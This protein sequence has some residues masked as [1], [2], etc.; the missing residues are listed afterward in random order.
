M[1][2]ATVTLCDPVKTCM[3]MVISA[4]NFLKDARTFV[5][6]IIKNRRIFIRVLSFNRILSTFDIPWDEFWNPG[7][8]SRID[9]II[10]EP[11]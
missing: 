8:L 11:N 3:I 5:T 1:R 6:L 2:F 7:L 10:F 9:V 4:L